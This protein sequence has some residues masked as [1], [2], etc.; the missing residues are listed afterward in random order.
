[1]SYALSLL[2]ALCHRALLAA[3]ASRITTRILDRIES[4]VTVS[5]STRTLVFWTFLVLVLIHWF[6]CVWG[7]VG[8]EQGTQRSGESEALRLATFAPASAATAANAATA[9]SARALKAT[10]KRPL[11]ELSD[12]PTSLLDVS[13]IADCLPGVGNCLSFCELQLLAAHTSTP[14]AYTMKQESWI[15]RCDHA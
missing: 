8:H 1:M 4:Y 14:L 15:C 12:D 7:L 13:Q 5:Y 10:T 3:R 9:A 11:G 2:D 6:C